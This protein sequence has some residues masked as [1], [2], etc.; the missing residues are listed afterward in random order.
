[1]FLVVGNVSVYSEAPMLI[2]S[3]SSLVL[4]G[5]VFEDAQRGKV[6]VRAFIW[7]SILGAFGLYCVILKK[8]R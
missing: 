7:V 3:I 4:V 5:L 8:T 1:M 6:C 2:L